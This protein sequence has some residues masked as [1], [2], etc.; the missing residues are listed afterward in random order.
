M[1]GVRPRRSLLSTGT[2]LGIVASFPL[3]GLA[4]FGAGRARAADQAPI[5]GELVPLE[6]ASLEVAQ[7][8]AKPPL[9]SSASASGSA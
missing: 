3:L 8:E 4:L 1:A 9:L 2:T 6:A 5:A 7:G